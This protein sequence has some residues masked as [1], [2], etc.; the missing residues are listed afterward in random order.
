MVSVAL[1]PPHASSVFVK[2][3]V[4]GEGCEGT[5]YITLLCMCVASGYLEVLYHDTHSKSHDTCTVEVE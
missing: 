4:L 3:L 2:R 5:Y 1:S